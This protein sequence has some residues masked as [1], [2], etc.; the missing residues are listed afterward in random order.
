MREKDR[1]VSEKKIS[2]AKTDMATN[3]TAARG[4]GEGV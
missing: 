4:S 2:A 1:M 3:T